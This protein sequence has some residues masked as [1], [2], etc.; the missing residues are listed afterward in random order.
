MPDGQP[1]ET[2]TIWQQNCRKSLDCQLD[3]VN[4]LQNTN[5]N[6]CLIQEP[7]LDNKRNTRTPPNWTAI[8]PPDHLLDKEP[9]TR[10]VILISPRIGAN[11]CTTIPINS[12][13]ISA[14][15]IQTTQ[16]SLRI[17]NVY[18]D[19]THSKTVHKLH[20]WT[21]NPQEHTSPPTPTFSTGPG[22]HTI[23]AGDFNRHHPAWDD[24]DQDQLFTAAAIRDANIL[25]DAVDNAGL[26]MALP[27][28][29]NT[30]ETTRGNWTRPDNV[31]LSHDL[32]DLIVKCDTDPSNRPIVTNHLPIVL[33][34]DLGVDTQRPVESYIWKEV[35]WSDLRI[36]LEAA[37]STY[38]PPR[39]LNTIAELEHAAILFDQIF[40]ELTAKH[41]RRVTISPHTKRWWTPDL[42]AAR[43]D[44][45]AMKLKS[46]NLRFEPE[47]PV[48]AEAK[49]TA[50]A[51][52]TLMRQTK[53]EHWTKF[54][55]SAADFN[56]WL[57]HRTV[58]G[59][60]SDGGQTRLPALRGTTGDYAVDCSEKADVL[61]QEFFPP[62][63]EVEPQAED[64][65]D[66]P[67]PFEPFRQVTDEQIHRAIRHMDPWKAVMAG[68]VP[69]AMIKK[70]ADILV[71]YL[72]EMY[73]ATSAWTIT[74]QTGGSTTP[75][76][77][78]SQDERTT[79]SRTPTAPY[80]CSRPL[81]NHYQSRSRST[82]HT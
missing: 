40:E 41:V 44:S 5:A 50:N 75:S 18:N 34:L 36:D 19:I 21:D 59:T 66:V 60:G 69:N 38:G 45:R 78:G 22:A 77:S 24:D 17:I 1:I 54:I 25:L 9:R 37:L 55:E 63:P 32:V 8:Y 70:C 81:R 27:K 76:C 47:H 2:V 65:D 82:C 52:K 39:Q 30:L 61:H 62:P 4:S 58:T 33:E 68:D 7:Y 6:I 12:P 42:T 29:T 57:V 23:W 64:E 71:P 43:K 56:I 13:D 67:A 80:V 49:R 11:I 14:I 28:G 3:L 74:P 26:T 15:Q 73:R 35:E 51:Y 79:Q 72:G 16:G 53:Q 10:S 48:H 46:Y 20:A 31:F